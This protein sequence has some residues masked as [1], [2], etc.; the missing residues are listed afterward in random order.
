[1]RFKMGFM[2]MLALCVAFAGCKN[3]AQVEAETAAKS[4]EQDKLQGKWKVVSREGDE[5]EGEEPA[6]ASSYYVIEGDIFKFVYKGSDGKEE[7]YSR[8]KLSFPADKDP[9][10][11]DMTYVDE[12]GKPLKEAKVKK[13]FTG[14]KKVTTTEMKDVAIYK[15][16]GDKLTMAISFDDK[17]RPTNFSGSKGSSSYVLTLEKI[18]DGKEPAETPA[19][20]KVDDTPA[21]KKIDDTPATKKADTPATKKAD[22]TP[23]TKKADTT[24]TK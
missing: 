22:G 9:K 14:N 13:G 6:A 24:P 1:M 15:I 8:K 20:K 7:E 12:S 16:D 19:T 21:T 5:E 11:L 23:A 3:K 18:K 10:Q 17:K 4:V 2:S